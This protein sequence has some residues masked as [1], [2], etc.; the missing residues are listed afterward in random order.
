MKDR[1]ISYFLLVLSSLLCLHG[2]TTAQAPSADGFDNNAEKLRAETFLRVWS[3]VNE[4]HYDPAFGGVDWA[5]VRKRYEP[6]ALAAK[7]DEE[8]Y[9]ILRQMLGE[10]KLSH[11]S[12][13]RESGDS[14]GSNGS[15]DPGIE[16]KMIGNK[17]VV[18]R[19]HDNEDLKDPLKP[20]MILESIDG[21]RITG[22]LKP[23][24]ESLAER[25]LTEASK[26][27]YRERFLEERMRGPLGSKV[28]LSFSDGNGH[29]ISDEF[30]RRKFAGEL[31][32]RLGNFPP[33]PV[34]FESKMLDGNIG[35]FRFNMWV[36]PQMPK[37]REALKEFAGAEGII[38]DL[39]GNPGGLGA[40]AN[41]LAGLMI[42]DQASLGS[43]PSRSGKM[44]FIAYPQTD[45]FLGPVVIIVDHGSGSTSEVF[46]A[47]MQET[48]RAV[49]VGDTTAGAVLPSVFE[50]LPT[51][52]TFQYA[53]SDYRSPRSVLI[54]G[55]GVL[56]DTKVLLD[57]E[58]L[59]DGKD[60][61]LEKALEII[62]RMEKNN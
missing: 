62:K 14:G 59:L 47:G 30:S 57:R 38:I 20:G 9:S 23:L 19:Y 27:L 8:L 55:R 13:F 34:V 44:E 50:K 40:M 2:V 61:Q 56:P 37:I 18:F 28:S 33:Q 11:F 41:G 39:R 25:Q 4:K 51:G 49:V 5:D 22:L 21:E 54:E 46:A 17:A 35:Y 36:V 1:K 58:M 42:T 26:R 31:S 52:A 53:V 45:P 3:T 60:S 43:M 24:E 12:I 16:L 10:L 32:Q 7:T 48:G 6:K 15:G 29:S